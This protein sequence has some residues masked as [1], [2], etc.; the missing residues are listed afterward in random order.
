MNTKLSV[1]KTMLVVFGAALFMAGVVLSVLGVPRVVQ[2]GTDLSLKTIA[3]SD[4]T[5][6]AA[7]KPVTALT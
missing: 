4:S 7:T 6:L 5:R 3:N 2:A 1:V